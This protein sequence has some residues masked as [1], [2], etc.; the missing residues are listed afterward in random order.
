ML[1]CF[2]PQRGTVLKW[3]TRAETRNTPALMGVMSSNIVWKTGVPNRTRANDTVRPYTTCCITLLL[4]R[5][6]RMR[7]RVS[8]LSY[9]TV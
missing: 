2:T 6:G 7:M 1:T 4:V 5:Y 9:D 8:G 3:R